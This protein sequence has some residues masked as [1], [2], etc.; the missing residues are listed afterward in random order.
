MGT[1]TSFSDQRKRT[2]QQ[3]P[4]AHPSQIRTNATRPVTNLPNEPSRFDTLE[5]EQSAHREAA[6]DAAG[7][8]FV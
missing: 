5:I 2:L 1:A 4:P 6:M 3:A 8:P 7:N